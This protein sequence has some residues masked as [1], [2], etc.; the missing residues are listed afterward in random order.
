MLSDEELKKLSS[1]SEN[2]IFKNYKTLLSNVNAPNFSKIEKPEIVSTDSLADMKNAL[3]VDVSSL[4]L[5]AAKLLNNVIGGFAS[6]FSNIPSSKIQTNN[7]KVDGN[8]SSGSIIRDLINLIVAIIEMPVRFAYLFQSGLQASAALSLGIGGLTQSVALGT[9]DLYLLIIAI[10]K[11]II[12]YFLCILSFVISTIAGCSLVHP[13]TFFFVLLYLFVM[14]VLKYIRDKT[15][16][17]FTGSFDS[18]AEY[19]QWPSAISLLCYSCFGKKVKLRDILADVGV[20]QEI[21]NMISD[22]FNNVMP[23][24]MKP[25]VP[26]GSAALG[27][28]DKAMN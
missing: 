19:V 16:V 13:I 17:D 14:E 5:D 6:A 28:L 21:G 7:S 23:R 2:D 10:V 11:I 1:I 12:K 3:N 26:L 18:M 15:T 9:K 20:I 8:G 25:S 22:D 4:E 27:S 24:Y